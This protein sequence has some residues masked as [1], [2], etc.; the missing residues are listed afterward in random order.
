MTTLHVLRSEPDGQ[1]RDL[2]K[3]LTPGEI[4]QIALYDEVVD[5]DRLIDEIFGHDRV[6]SWW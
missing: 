4:K 5:Y 2:I 6:I 1:V 3:M